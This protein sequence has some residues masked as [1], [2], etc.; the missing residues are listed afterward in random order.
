MPGLTIKVVDEREGGHDEEIFSFAGGI[1]EF[2]EFLA[3]DRPIT[4]TLRFTGSGKFTETVPVLDEQGHMTPADVERE[5]FVDVALRWGTDYDNVI[6]SFVNII[7]TP[8][9]GTHLAGFDKRPAEGGQRAAA[10]GQA[11][12]GQR[13]RRDPRRRLRGPDR[14]GHRPAGRA[15]V[16]GPDQGGPGHPGRQPHRGAGRGE[17]VQG[18]PDLGQAQRQADGARGAGEDRHAASTR[19]TARQHKEAQRRKNALE[20][21]AL[22]AKLADCRSDDVDRTEMFI[23]EGDSAMGSAKAARNSEFQALLP[24]RGKILNVQKASSRTC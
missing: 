23:I 17:L 7:A 18:V 16:R 15:A 2:V 4:D 8:K 5:L 9:G 14:G 21:S 12:E 24:I 6:R 3:P 1:S 19:I 22:P 10:R 20:T 11:A 13:R